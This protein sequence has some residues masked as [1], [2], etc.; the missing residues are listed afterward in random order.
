M[1]TYRTPR[2]EA[3]L[4]QIGERF[5]AATLLPARDLFRS[6]AEW[7]MRWPD[8]LPTLTELVFFPESDGTIGLGVWSEL[9]D[10]AD[11]LPIWYLD[12]AGRWF[13]LAAVEITVTGDSLARFATVRVVDQ[14]NDDGPCPA[15]APT[16]GA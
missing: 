12:D 7:R 9:H 16:D 6:T 15:A 4:S 14:A 1:T 11:Q 2:Y 8:L 5:P 3:K 10:A 13:P